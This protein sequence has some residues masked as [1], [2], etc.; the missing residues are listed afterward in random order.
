MKT[1]IDMFLTHSEV[2]E[3]IDPEDDRVSFAVGFINQFI[4]EAYVTKGR[5]ARCRLEYPAY[6]AVFNDMDIHDLVQ[7]IRTQIEWKRPECVHIFVR[8]AQLDKFIEI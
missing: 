8:F 7:H 6:T 4:D 2:E 1:K 5:F 3:D